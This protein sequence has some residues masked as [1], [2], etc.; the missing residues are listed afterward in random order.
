MPSSPHRSGELGVLADEPPARPHRLGPARAQRTGQPRQVQVGVRAR[1][2]HPAVRARGVR[3]RPDEQRLVR[4]PDEHRPPVRGGV[5][6]DRAQRWTALGVP[7]AHGVDQP[8]RRFAPVDD[9]ESPEGTSPGSHVAASVH[10]SSPVHRS[11]RTAPSSP[12]VQP[13]R[14][15]PAHHPAMCAPWAHEA[16]RGGRPRQLRELGG[17][18]RGAWGGRSRGDGDDESDGG[19]GRAGL[20]RDHGRPAG[21]GAGGAAARVPAVGALL[22]G[23]HARAHR[24][25][26]AHVRAG[27]A[28]LLAGRPSH[29]ACRVPDDRGGRRR[30]GGRRGRTGGDGTVARARRRARLGR[31]RR[32]DARRDPAR[33]RP[34]RHRDLRAAPARHGRRAAQAPP[35]ARVVV[36]GG[37][38]RARAGRARVRRPGRHGA[39]RRRWSACSSGPARAGSAPSATPPASP[40][41]PRSPR[42]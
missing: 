3:V 18:A 39:G 21:R 10:G 32:L 34:H 19:A 31:R 7:L 41:R 24:R 16:P 42:R 2:V 38:R 11:P 17:S 4:L 27:P 30:R 26:P 6:G 15:R 23:R 8:H 29:R 22:G 40:T 9:R 25:R 5:Q 35:A 28:W 36:H 33:A 37:V 13:T 20:R 14:R 1:E 12:D